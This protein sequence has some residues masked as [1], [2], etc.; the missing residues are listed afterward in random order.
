MAQ[1]IFPRLVHQFIVDV[2]ALVEM[3]RDLRMAACKIDDHTN[4]AAVY[5]KGI[6]STKLGA[7]EKARE[8]LE[9]LLSFSC[10]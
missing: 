8:D 4:V 2:P 5:H 9:H 7:Q 1:N 6:G 10:A 3:V